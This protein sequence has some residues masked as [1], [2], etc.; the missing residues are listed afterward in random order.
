M[1][2]PDIG[3]GVSVIQ[4]RLIPV[5]EASRDRR[6]LGKWVELERESLEPNPFFAPQMVLPAARHLEDGAS[7]QLLVAESADGLL[8]LMPVTERMGLRGMPV[9][10]L[11]SWMHDYCYLGTPLFSAHDDP[12]RIWT[13]IFDELRR[14]RPA[15]LL[16]MQL[17]SADGPVAAGLYR[18]GAQRGLRV[19]RSPHA[20]RGFIHR[21]PEFKYA[22][23][24]ISRKHRADLARRR[25]SL[26]RKLDAEI[27]TVDR[28]AS[29]PGKAIEQFLQLEARGW[30]GRTGT[31]F[32]R[33]PGHDRFFREM[34]RSFSDDGRLMFLSLEAG[35]QVLAQNTALIG[36]VG[37]FGF[38]KTYD[39]TFARWS[40]GS[41]LDLDVLRWF[42][43]MRQLAWLD[44][45]SGSND[46]AT[47][48]VFGDRRATRTLAV[49]I[50]PLGSAAAAMLPVVVGARRYL[51]NSE[52]GRMA[53][54]HRRASVQG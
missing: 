30:K 35:T 12:A 3:E 27:T 49:P 11:R 51:R 10:G 17:H 41:L 54:Q 26:G 43:E 8:F 29:D 2:A 13:K 40:P 53:R 1:A 33:R 45:G 52:A 34:S 19:R 22:C 15:S 39:E 7:T 38:R 24:W 25:R 18:A 42:H 46:E 32:L 5:V 21:R 36:G 14:T 47:R 44:T 9:P 16:V 23:E 48:R 31:A 37:L 20:D 6:F 28:A 50:S 4:V